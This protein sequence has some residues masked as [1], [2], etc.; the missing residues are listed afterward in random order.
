[1]TASADRY[2]DVQLD[3]TPWQIVALDVIPLTYVRSPLKWYR[4]CEIRACRGT[5][6]MSTIAANKRLDEEL[7]SARLARQF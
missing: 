6:T 2:V 4:L 1:V 3:G 7:S 5:E